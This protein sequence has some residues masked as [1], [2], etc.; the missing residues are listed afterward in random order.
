MRKFQILIPAVC[1]LAL[2][3]CKPT[4]G[5]YRTAYEQAM[6]K[7]QKADPDADLIYGG[8]AKLSAIGAIDEK[9]DGQEVK[10]LRRAVE[11][12]DADSIAE[13]NRWRVAVALYKMPSNAMSHMA[14]L[15]KS[16]LSG[17]AVAKGGEEKYFVIAHS[18]PSPKAAAAWAEA[19][20]RDHPD[21]RY[22]GLD[23][24]RPLL[25]FSPR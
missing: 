6:V 25:L 16:G 2:A 9:I 7:K 19:Y 14:D 12:I 1:I 24:D 8:H 22:I 13:A 23:Q 3:G 18:A 11:L 10:T 15:R 21:H 17:T 5:N 20:R 4:E